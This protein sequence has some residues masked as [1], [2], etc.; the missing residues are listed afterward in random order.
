MFWWAEEDRTDHL[1]IINHLVCFM[2][3]FPHTP[4]Y[5]PKLLKKSNL[6]NL[7]Y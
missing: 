6:P 7:N 4:K 3:N 5:T 1:S 2:R